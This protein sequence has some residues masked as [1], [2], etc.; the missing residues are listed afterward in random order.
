MLDQKN[1]CFCLC[2]LNCMEWFLS[3]IERDWFHIALFQ[4]YFNH[5][6]AIFLL[7][8]TR[9]FGRGAVSVEILPWE[10]WEPLSASK[11]LSFLIVANAEEPRRATIRCQSSTPGLFHPFF[12]VFLKKTFQSAQNPKQR[13]VC[14]QWAVFNFL[15]FDLC[16]AC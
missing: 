9:H 1:V 5:R 7:L 8:I 14:L 11:H 6:A 4:S 2:S 16:D 12:S 10:S 15:W 13:P 3:Q